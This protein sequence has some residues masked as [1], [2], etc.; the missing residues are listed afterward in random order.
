MK[1]VRG[2]EAAYDY[3]KLKFNSNI[4]TYETVSD[5][6]WCWDTLVHDEGSIASSLW[7]FVEE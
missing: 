4:S 7:S 5:L 3:I 6:L 1:A 2:D